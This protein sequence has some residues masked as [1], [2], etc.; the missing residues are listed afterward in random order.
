MTTSG[1]PDPFDRAAGAASDR[2]PERGG[3]RPSLPRSLREP[4]VPRR[5]PEV[6]AEAADPLRLQDAL[7]TL[8]RTV[9]QRI[10]G[11]GG[12]RR[13]GAA[14][15]IVERGAAQG[16]GLRVGTLTQF[17]PAFEVGEQRVHGDS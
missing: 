7:R 4:A 6:Q 11:R 8:G 5:S 15:E 10:A 2:P 3:E 13:V 1:R 17:V 16:L 14:P 12:Q 9:P